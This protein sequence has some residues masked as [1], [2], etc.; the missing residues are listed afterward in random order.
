MIDRYVYLANELRVGFLLKSW[1]PSLYLFPLF[2]SK[3]IQSI[4]FRNYF[5]TTVLEKSCFM[6]RSVST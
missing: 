1:L 6:S 4:S 2:S 3:E 5:S